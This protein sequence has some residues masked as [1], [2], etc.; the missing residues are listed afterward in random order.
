MPCV[1][2]WLESFM[3]DFGSRR[4]GAAVTLRSGGNEYMASLVVLFSEW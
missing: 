3:L 2:C 4:I 1:E